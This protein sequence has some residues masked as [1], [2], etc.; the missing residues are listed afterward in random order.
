MSYSH[1]H[2]PYLIDLIDYFSLFL[3]IADVF[4]Q[5]VIFEVNE[6]LQVLH[7]PE[8]PESASEP[9]F[10]SCLEFFKIKWDFLHFPFS[11]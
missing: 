6:P 5:C 10:I 1:A 11:C 7:E 8:F 2:N 4:C 3:L 9:E